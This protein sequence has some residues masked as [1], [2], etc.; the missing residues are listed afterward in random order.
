[1]RFFVP[2][3]CT[4]QTYIG[5]VIRLLSIFDFVLEFVDLFKFFNIWR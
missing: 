3:F 2:V 4:D 1:M 5:Q